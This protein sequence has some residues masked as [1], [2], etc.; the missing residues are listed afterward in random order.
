[1]HGN[2]AS[3]I[4]LFSLKQITIIILLIFIYLLPANGQKQSLPDFTWGNAAYFNLNVGEAIYFD[5]TELKLLEIK[6]HYNRIKIGNDTV[7]VKVSRRTLPFY[8]SGLRIF[9]ADNKN[10]KE[11]TDDSEVHDLLTK[12]ALICVSS[13]LHPMLD[14]QHY[15]FPISFSDGFVW[16]GEESG[17]M[18]AY[19]G[20]IEQNGEKKQLSQ[21]GIE[22]DLQDARGK[23]KH[24]IVA[25][26]NSKVAWIE[27]KTNN[28]G[29]KQSTVLL[30]SEPQTEI[31][32]LYQRL[33]GKNVQVRRG[34]QLMRGEPL[35]TAGGNGSEGEF[36]FSVIKSDTVPS[37]EFRNGNIV[38]F[39]PQIFEL[40][41]N[42]TDNFSKRFSK[43]RISF[44]KTS[45]RSGNEMNN[46]AF[47]EYMGKGWVFGQWNIADKVETVTKGEQGNVRLQ[48]IIFGNSL[49]ERKNPNDWFD[50]EIN[51]PDGTYRIRAKVGDAGLAATQQVLFEGVNAGTFST[52]KGEYVWTPERVVRVTDGKLTVRIKVDAQNQKPAGLSEIVFQRAN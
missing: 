31:F 28:G 5:Q 16:K 10:V 47:E 36:Q 24:W 37:Y 6:N 2:D 3:I 7:W 41:F 4:K 19:L 25:I 18:F 34:Q 40:Y 39:F 44:G 8:V 35:G 23:E 20:L 13:F 29:E 51:V 52:A 26:E 49:A 21:S 48:R 42:R 11:L 30:Q 38:N 22:F 50:Y 33:N 43:G 17:Y 12:D 32:Y 9:V 15:I 27:T 1:M 46:E 45:H 14:S